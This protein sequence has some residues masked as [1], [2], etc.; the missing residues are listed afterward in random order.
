M[1]MIDDAEPQEEP[2]PN[3]DGA[4]QGDDDALPASLISTIAEL[5]GA[6]LRLGVPL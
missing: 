4:G 1:L 3:A 2:R 5:A 6:A